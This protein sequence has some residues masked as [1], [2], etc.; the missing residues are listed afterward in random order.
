MLAFLTQTA[1]FHQDIVKHFGGR[2][3]T[4]QLFAEAALMHLQCDLTEG[5]K[6]KALQK[7]QALLML[8]HYHWA[9]CN[10]YYCDLLSRE[11]LTF[12]LRQRDQ[13]VDSVD[14]D[15]KEIDILEKNRFIRQEALRRTFWCAFMMD[16]YMSS[17]RERL[18]II[19][20]DLHS[21]VQVPCNDYNFWHGRPVKT[22]LFGETDEDFEQR[23]KIHRQEEE[24]SIEWED[25]GNEG[26]LGWWMLALDCLSEVNQWANQTGERYASNTLNSL[27]YGTSSG[28][29][30][31]KIRLTRVQGDFRSTQRSS[32]QDP[33]RPAR[34]DPAYTHQH[35]RPSL[36]TAFH[37]LE[38]VF[39]VT[40]HPYSFHDTPCIWIRATIW[41]P[42]SRARIR[43][44]G[45]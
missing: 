25:R 27:N 45:R 17:G 8:S 42:G 35:R 39:P 32:R 41:V 16:R 40:Y 3:K 24:R 23:K 37:Y 22:R 1:Q 7:T 30:W 4:A 19:P 13:Y 26:E 14:K 11:A 44:P 38:G 43:R 10:E 18:R 21:N 28:Q 12:L 31:A 29:C 34:R 2:S 36:R 6:R 33:T 15:A 9:T 20:G 5:L